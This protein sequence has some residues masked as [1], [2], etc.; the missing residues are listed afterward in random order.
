MSSHTRYQ[1]SRACPTA[2]RFMS[3]PE[4]LVALGFRY[5]TL[6]CRLGDIHA[7][8][9]AFQVYNCKLG[10]REARLAVSGLSSWA[11]CVNAA[12]RREICVA[13]AG[14]PKFCRDECLAVTMVAAC[15]HDACP[16]LKAC[17]FSLIEASLLD[18][19][20]METESF[21][22]ILRS[23]KQMLSPACIDLA[24]E[25]SDMPHPLRLH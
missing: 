9:Q 4:R 25:L 8:E 6:G 1:P 13:K 10:A 19:V 5:W 17:A 21:A 2:A 3:G 22:T 12:A 16:A 23:L 7:W 11:A 15:Q 18:D 20:M 14:A 24:T